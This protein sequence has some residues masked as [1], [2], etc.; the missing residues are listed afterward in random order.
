MAGE[1]RPP[2]TPLPIPLTKDHHC[3]KKTAHGRRSRFLHKLF[4]GN[5]GNREVGEEHP[6]PIPPPL[7]KGGG[8]YYACAAL[9]LR[10]DRPLP[11]ADLARFRTSMTAARCSDYRWPMTSPHTPQPSYHPLPYALRRP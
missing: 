1:H 10:Q 6:H 9:M 3:C 4:R 5:D 8:G 2:L 11:V 7:K